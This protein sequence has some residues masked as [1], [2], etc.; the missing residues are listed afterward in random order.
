MLHPGAKGQ[1]P[2][3]IRVSLK[4]ISD[5]LL[6]ST[7]SKNIAME[8]QFTAPFNERSRCWE[9]ATTTQEPPSTQVRAGGPQLL[10]RHVSSAFHSG[11]KEWLTDTWN[12]FFPYDLDIC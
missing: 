4:R 10:L 2:V 12:S 6:T 3:W 11:V 8:F 9:C 5:S 1:F 7:G